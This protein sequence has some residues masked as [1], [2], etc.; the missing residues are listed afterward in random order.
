MKKNSESRNKLSHLCS[1]DFQQGWQDN[2]MWERIVFSINGGGTTEY[3]YAK[4]W[5]ESLSIM[6]KN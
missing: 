3:P 5:R 1:T 6:C 4:E 2:S